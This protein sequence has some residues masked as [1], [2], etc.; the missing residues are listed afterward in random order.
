MEPAPPNAIILVRLSACVTMMS[1]AWRARSPTAAELVSKL[2]EQIL[3]P[4]D[5]CA[6]HTDRVFRRR[7]VPPVSFVPGAIV[8]FHEFRGLWFV[9]DQWGSGG[10]ARVGRSSPP[11]ELGTAVLS[12][13]EKARRAPRPLVIPAADFGSA[14]RETAGQWERFC[15]EVAG[16]LARGYQPEKRLVILADEQ[17]MRCHDARHSP[18]RLVPLAAS[19]PE[20]VGAALVTQLAAMA[21]RWPAADT[22][23]VTRDR[24]AILV[25]RRHGPMTAGPIARL[26]G[27]ATSPRSP[28]PGPSSTVRSTRRPVRFARRCAA[29]AGRWARSTPRLMCT[30]PGRRPAS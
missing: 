29:L 17:G 13:I 10:G 23:L 26:A 7:A 1:A 18:P 19:S 25:C 14:R 22:A 2:R 12:R 16:V 11:A 3:H 20:G 27:D 5:P 30:S 9:T 4:I 15:L 21:P 28:N 24:G 8:E 6:L